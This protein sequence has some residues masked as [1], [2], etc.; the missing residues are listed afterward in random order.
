MDLL[1]GEPEVERVLLDDLLDDPPV[2]RL[3][4][5]L[6]AWLLERPLLD[7]TVGFWPDEL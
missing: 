5:L 6:D 4:A 1:L 2:E 3:L 7:T